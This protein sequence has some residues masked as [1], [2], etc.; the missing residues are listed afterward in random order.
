MSDDNENDL[1]EKVR[2]PLHEPE[3]AP[4]WIEGIPVV[5]DHDANKAGAAVKGG[6]DD[7]GSAAAT[8]IGASW[9]S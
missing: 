7:N 2:G 9:H 8:N 4:T 5:L 6:Q 3:E 1:S